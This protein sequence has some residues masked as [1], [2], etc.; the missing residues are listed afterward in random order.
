MSS[1]TGRGYPLRLTHGG[2]ADLRSRY[3]APWLAEPHVAWYGLLERRWSQAASPGCTVGVARAMDE[4]TLQQSVR[5]PICLHI[6]DALCFRG[7]GVVRVRH[8]VAGCQARDAPHRL[9]DDG[10]A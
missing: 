10:E 9:D 5:H 1:D 3:T 7:E 4:I 2:N 8:A 6:G